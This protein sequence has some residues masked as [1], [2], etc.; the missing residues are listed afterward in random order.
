MI[1]CHQ[2]EIFTQSVNARFLLSENL[3]LNGTIPFIFVFS[4]KQYIFYNK[5]MWKN[6]HP[7]NG[8]GIQTHNFQDMSLLP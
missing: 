6:V 2:T 8:A 3:F 5:W 4:N 1:I 7:V